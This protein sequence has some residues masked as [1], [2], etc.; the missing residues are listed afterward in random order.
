MRHLAT[1]FREEELGVAVRPQDVRP[2]PE[3]GR[4]DRLADRVAH[5]DRGQKRLLRPGRRD[6]VAVVSQLLTVAEPALEVCLQVAGG[7]RAQ[8]R[9]VPPVRF[10]QL[11][12]DDD[13]ERDRPEGERLALHDDIGQVAESQ[14]VVPPV[15]PKGLDPQ[16]GVGEE[17][18]RD[19]FPRGRGEEDP[20]EFVLGWHAFAV[21]RWRGLRALHLDLEFP[22]DAVEGEPRPKGLERRFDVPSRQSGVFHR[23]DEVCQEV[24]ARIPSHPDEVLW[25]DLPGLADVPEA[26]EVHVRGDLGAAREV[27][28]PPANRRVLSQRRVL[29]PSSRPRSDSNHPSAMGEVR[30]IGFEPEVQWV[31]PDLNRSRQHPKLVGFLVSGKTS[32]SPRSNQATPR[33]RRELSNE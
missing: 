18:R 32:R 31:R 14:P 11:R 12:S 33:T 28:V 7:F 10:A 26:S 16:P 25:S 17:G 23:R 24:P 6:H 1:A 20:A 15:I 2:P 19:P 21:E 29:G 5:I 3:A 13:L 30:D 4:T 9:E 8:E 22:Q 27:P